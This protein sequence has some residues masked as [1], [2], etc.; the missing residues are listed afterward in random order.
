MLTLYYFW[1]KSIMSLKKGNFYYRIWK[2]L[3]I[4]LFLNIKSILLTGY[5]IDEIKN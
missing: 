3:F 1:N 2:Q 4:I 5:T